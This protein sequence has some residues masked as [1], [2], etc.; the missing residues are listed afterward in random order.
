MSENNNS[1]GTLKPTVELYQQL[2]PQLQQS[3]TQLQQSTTQLQQPTTQYYYLP[4]PFQSTG[5]GASPLTV[6]GGDGLMTFSSPIL[7]AGSAVLGS[8]GERE[9]HVFFSL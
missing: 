4:P 6:G 8:K 1:L 5:T 9:V 7:P 3:T 2:N